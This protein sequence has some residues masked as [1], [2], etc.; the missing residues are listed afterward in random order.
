MQ[1]DQLLSLT[2]PHFSRLPPDLLFSTVWD[3]TVHP[4]FFPFVKLH[5]PSLR[6][7]RSNLL[8]T[9]RHTRPVPQT[10]SKCSTH[11]FLGCTPI[12]PLFASKLPEL[13]HTSELALSNLQDTMITAH[14]RATLHHITTTP[15]PEQLVGCSA[16]RLWAI[17][18]IPI[19]RTNSSPD[20]MYDESP[21]PAG[22]TNSRNYRHPAVIRV[23]SS[24]P[25]PHR[26][27]APPHD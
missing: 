11:W 10:F 17:N 20:A 2:T 6:D 16:S 24:T 26:P 27:A 15:P 23:A 22:A 8:P 18:L 19:T 25:T 14:Q 12:S 9:N 21:D 3:T 5:L 4:S 7:A 1:W 13:G